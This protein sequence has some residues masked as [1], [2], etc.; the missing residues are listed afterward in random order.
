MMQKTLSF[1]TESSWL[2]TAA[3]EQ[4][5]TDK[6]FYHQ[7][8]IITKKDQLTCEIACRLRNDSGTVFRI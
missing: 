4:S 3:G 2:E 8:V 5:L 6:H 7:I 1:G